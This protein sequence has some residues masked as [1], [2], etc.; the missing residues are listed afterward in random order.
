MPRRVTSR[1]VAELAGV[2]RTTVSFVLNDV[3]SA[4]IGET[5]RTKVLEAAR[6]LGYHPHASARRLVTGQTNL[7]AY[8]ERHATAQVFS[9]S[10]WPEVLRGVHDGALEFDHELLF[11]PDLVLNGAGRTSRL[12]LGN[13]VDGVIISGPQTEDHEVIDLLELGVP[14]VIQGAWPDP[15]VPSVDV[16]NRAAACAATEHLIQLGH[17]RIGIILHA[18]ASYTSA[19]LRYEGYRDALAQHDLAHRAA[20][21]SQA[22]FTPESGEA[23]MDHILDSEGRP[24]AVFTTSDTVAIGAM[25]SARRHGLS[26]PD[27]MALVG[28][29]DVPISRYI[30][31]ALTTVRLPAY[32]LGR[33]SA[34]LMQEILQEAQ[35]E[36]SRR[37]LPSE[38]I[39][40]RSCGASPT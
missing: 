23:A 10:F 16:D 26:I 12:L 30:E 24:T 15:E 38:L 25:R 32:D 35:P 7:I 20:L 11:A 5:T 37:I 21:E 14:I 31:P 6:T 28:F 9:D 4:R 27:D 40:R 18:P 39:V 2:S 13:Y 1:Q 19:S 33:A 36:Q 3:P 34:A 8:V 29:D 22:L 17:E